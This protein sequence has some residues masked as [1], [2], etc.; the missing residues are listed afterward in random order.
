[1]ASKIPTKSTPEISA[2]DEKSMEHYGI[3][4]VPVDYFWFGEYRYSSLKDAIAQ[5]KR[6]EKLD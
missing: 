6:Q 1:M 5:A 3:I 2:E 4:Q